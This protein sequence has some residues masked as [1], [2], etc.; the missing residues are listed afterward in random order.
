MNRHPSLP[1]YPP[2]AAF[3]FVPVLPLGGPATSAAIQ[4]LN[5]VKDPWSAKEKV[6]NVP[7]QL[8]AS[9]SDRRPAAIVQPED[10]LL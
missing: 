8:I 5:T 6:N 1:R 3:L 9:P 2:I 7:G 10:A 4:P